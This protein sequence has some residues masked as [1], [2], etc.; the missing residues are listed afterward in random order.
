MSTTLGGVKNALQQAHRLAGRY[1][2][3]R[4]LGRGGMGV[5]YAC[6][7]IVTGEKVAVKLLHTADGTPL[8]GTAAVVLG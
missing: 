3:I 6:L 4:E 2:V 8:P 5:V 7:D 1:D